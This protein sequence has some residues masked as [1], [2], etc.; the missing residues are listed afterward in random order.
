MDHYISWHEF[1]AYQTMM[2]S[3]GSIPARAAKKPRYEELEIGA[4]NQTPLIE[5]PYELCNQFAAY[6]WSLW[7]VAFECEQLK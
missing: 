3:L 6:R 5:V 1:G 4:N 2:M 7:F